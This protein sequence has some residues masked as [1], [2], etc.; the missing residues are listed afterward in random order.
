MSVTGGQRQFDID[1][2]RRLHGR[3][4]I[5]PY[6]YSRTRPSST[7]SVTIFNA[8]LIDLEVTM[9]VDEAVIMMASMI[10]DDRLNDDVRSMMSDR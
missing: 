1:D 8:S 10:H 6:M 9:K 5:K 2:L 3:L 7:R 4:N